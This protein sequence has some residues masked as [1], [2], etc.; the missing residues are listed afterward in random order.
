MNTTLIRGDALW[1]VTEQACCLAL[2]SGR[3]TDDFRACQAAAESLADGDAGAL[4]Y[5]GERTAAVTHDDTGFE[6]YDTESYEGKEND[7]REA[8]TRLAHLGLDMQAPVEKREAFMKA[9]DL[10][11]GFYDADDVLTAALGNI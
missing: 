8:V 9:A 6:D 5:F 11:A 10:I 1:F 4:A 7:L 2:A 3:E